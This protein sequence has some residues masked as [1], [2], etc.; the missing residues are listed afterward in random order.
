MGYTNYWT[1]KKPFNNSKWNIIKKEYDYI[2]ENFSDDDGIIE[3]QT[4]K[5]DEI[6]FN[7]KSKNDQDHETFVLTKNFREPFYT[8][9]DVKFNFCKTA[10]KPYDLAVWHLLTFVKMIAPNSIDIR[11]DGWYHGEKEND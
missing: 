6:I 3:D 7:G 1:Q 8:G 10:R 5:S 9:D 4:K 2:K 11:R